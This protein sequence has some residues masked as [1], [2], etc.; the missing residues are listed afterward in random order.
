MSI[1]F[2]TALK[3]KNPTT[4]DSAIYYLDNLQLQTVKALRKSADGYLPMEKSP[5][6][7]RLCRQPPQTALINTNLTIDA[8][9][10]FQLLTPTGEIAYEGTSEKKTTLGEFG[11]IDFHLPIIPEVSAEGQNIA[12]STFGLEKDFGKIHNGKC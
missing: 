11:L 5:I 7:N 12:N 10:R 1:T 4:G 9:K 8:G 3:G 6:D 2:S